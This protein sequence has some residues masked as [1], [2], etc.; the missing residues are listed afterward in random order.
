MLR[1]DG[2]CGGIGGISTS[3]LR[4]LMVRHLRVL[5]NR[6]RFV[7]LV[8]GLAGGRGGEV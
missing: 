6:E 7:E 5:G 4:G 1:R 8:Y 3:M 2:S